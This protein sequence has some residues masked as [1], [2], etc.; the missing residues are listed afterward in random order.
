MF[1]FLRKK[2]SVY[3][4]LI[5]LIISFWFF[6]YFNSLPDVPF[7]PDESTQ[8]FMSKDVRLLFNN[9][10]E[11]FYEDNPVDQV[12]QN[13]R[14]LDAPVTKYTIGT[15]LIFNGLQSLKSDWDWTKTW[16]ENKSSIPTTAQLLTSRIS[17]ALFFPISILLFFLLLKEFFKDKYL[18][19][20]LGIVM[21]A[22]NSLLLLHTRRSMAESPLIFFLLLS[23]Y[24]LLKLPKR[25]LY[26]S[27]IPI[28]LAINSKQTLLFLIPLAILLIIL[29]YKN[30]LVKLLIQCILFFILISGIHIA[31][32][33]IT[34]SDPIKTLSTMV[35]I[36]RELTMDQKLAIQSVSPEFIVETFPEKLIAYIGQLYILEPQPQEI[37][38]YDS[39]LRNSITHYFNNT[40]FKGLLRTMATGVIY[41]MIS[42]IGLFSSSKL[43]S[44]K[45]KLILMGGWILFSIEVLLFNQI[46]FQRYYLPAIPFTIILFLFGL[47]FIRL[48]ILKIKRQNNIGFF[49]LPNTRENH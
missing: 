2:T 40:L 22:F 11:L 36:R 46:P 42:I 47:E 6:L 19:I 41:F 12:E 24:A 38:N 3:Y 44:N 21:F 34:W 45:N 27:S 23:L 16:D 35:K 31:L 39:E 8:I 26:F 32:N 33:P 7:H 17:I 10:S 43:L 14:L 30:Q 5:G 29:N 13:Y 48:N 49:D 15:F 1:T 28:A 4:T 25:Y 18:I 37:G 9:T 20:T